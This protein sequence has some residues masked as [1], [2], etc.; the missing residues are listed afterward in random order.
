MNNLEAVEAF[1]RIMMKKRTWFVAILLMIFVAILFP[2]CRSISDNNLLRKSEDEIFTEMQET[3]ANKLIQIINRLEKKLPTYE[4]KTTLLPFYEALIHK[5][6]EFSEDEL[7]ELILNKKT[8]SGIDCA[9]VEMYISNE[10]DVAKLSD[11]LSN[12]DIAD[13]TKEYIVSHGNYSVDELSDIFRKYDSSISVIAIQR[14]IAENSDVSMNLVDELLSSDFDKVSDEKC[15]AVCLGIAAYFEEHR[16]TED[17]NAMRKDFVPIL[18]KFF[19]QSNSEL[20]KDQ[21]IYALGRIADNELFSWLMDNNDVD[22][23]LKIS[24]IERNC[25]RMIEWVSSAKSESEIQSVIYAMQMHPIIEIANALQESIDNG[26][27]RSTSELK[28][29]IDYSIKEGIHV[30]DKYDS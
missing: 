4:S 20:V 7:I 18:K 12:S 29:L 5:A 1:G 28:A 14:I 26:N 3:S 22:F 16:T 6:N 2:I 10:Y 23:Y 8:L 21:A 27:I 17:G 11:L 15:K 19:Q 24:V 30:V 25:N 9:L 13:E